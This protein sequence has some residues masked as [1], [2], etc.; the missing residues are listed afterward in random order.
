MVQRYP[1]LDHLVT[2][3]TEQSIM[4]H[5]IPAIR[6][7]IAHNTTTIKNHIATKCKQ[8]TLKTPNIQNY[9]V[10]KTSQTKD[11]LKLP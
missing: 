1:Q 4:A 8:A 2:K 11:N 3:N 7:W 10:K 5:S 9:F 6:Q